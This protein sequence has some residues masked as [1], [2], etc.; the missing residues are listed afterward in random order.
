MDE[1]ELS[2][3]REWFVGFSSSFHGS[4]EEEQRNIALKEEHTGLVCAN[5]RRIAREE[6]RDAGRVALAEACA[7]FHDIGRFPQYRRYGTFKDSISVNHG[8][9]GADL[10]AQ[11]GA[12]DKFP[13]NEQTIVIQAVRHHNAFA[14]PSSLDAECAFYL[15]LVRDADKLDIWR[16]FLEFYRLP[17]G[18]RA[19]AVSLGFPDLPGCSPDVIEALRRGEMVRLARVRSLNDFK[20]LQLSWVYDLNFSVSFRMLLE[21]DYIGGLG[22]VLPP[23]EEV[24]RAVQAVREFAL[25]AAAR[26]GGDGC[27]ISA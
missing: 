12:L 11:G 24:E 15:R 8:V 9:L 16:V 3:L 27:T 26:T 21:R 20:L 5:I 10:L 1:R 19:S 18:E 22:K 14:V 25:C 13:R 17:E 7:L 2:H 6:T 4:S 23:D